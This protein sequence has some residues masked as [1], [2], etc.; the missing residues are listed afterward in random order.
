MKVIL[1]V[2]E[3]TIRKTVEY[4]GK[5]YVEDLREGREDESFS[6]ITDANLEELMRND[7]VDDKIIE[8]IGDMDVIELYEAYNC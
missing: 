6:Y 2:G 8:S 3:N 1:E 7:G 5:I 4:N